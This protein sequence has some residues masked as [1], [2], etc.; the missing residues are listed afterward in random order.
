MIKVTNDAKTFFE[1]EEGEII[2][3]GAGNAGYWVGYYMNLCGVEYSLYIDKN[4]KFIGIMYNEH[5]IFST[6]KLKEFSGRHIRMV[7]T[8]NVYKEVLA[9]LLWWD[10]LWEL[11]ILCAIPQYYDIAEKKELYN[12]NRFLGYFRRKQFVGGIPTIISNTC[13]AGHIYEAMNMPLLSPTINTGIS[14]NDFIKLCNNLEYYLSCEL[15]PVYWEK[16]VRTDGVNEANYICRLD[17]LRIEFAHLDS[18]DGIVERWKMMC[19]NINWDNVIYVMEEQNYR[20]AIAPSVCEAFLKLK[21]KK[22]IFQTINGYG[23]VKDQCLYSPMSFVALRREP[24]IEN[25]FD[26]LDWM[27]R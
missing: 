24:A 19:E 7:I 6:E 26:L 3:Y 4:V 20:K 2:I 9:D 12:I 10:H 22:I 14:D 8:P 11:D 1:K 18:E 13:A 27:M 17:D 16:G 25:S 5:S 15:V 23:N 21:G